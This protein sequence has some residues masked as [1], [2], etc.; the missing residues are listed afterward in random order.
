[1]LQHVINGNRLDPIE[2]PLGARNWIQ[3]KQKECEERERQ[4]EEHEKQAREEQ[5]ELRLRQEIKI[6]KDWDNRV[7]EFHTQFPPTLNS[8]FF[9]IDT[10]TFARNRMSHNARMEAA[11]AELE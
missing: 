10:T 11:L 2:K 6:A 1:M 4:H 9:T 5:E 8:H 7:T 3:H